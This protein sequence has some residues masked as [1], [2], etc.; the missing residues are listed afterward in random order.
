MKRHLW[1]GAGLAGVLVLGL[2]ACASSSRDA[3]TTTAASGS[4]Q[5]SGSA[6]EGSGGQPANPD[7]QFVFGAAGAPSMFDPLYA[8]DGETFRVARQINEG[9]IRFKPGTADPEPA[10]ATDWEQSTDGKTWT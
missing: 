3:G 6:G 7:G 9:L 5:A 10:L 1:L 4:A 2:T 8:T